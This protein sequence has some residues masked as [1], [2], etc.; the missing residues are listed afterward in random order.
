MAFDNDKLDPAV[1][2][3]ILGQC[4]TKSDRRYVDLVL[5]HMER[6]DLKLPSLN[7]SYLT[8]DERRAQL[9]VITGG[10]K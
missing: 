10:K 8:P 4:Q 7:Y 3:R 1:V 2:D 6:F 5:G 9:K